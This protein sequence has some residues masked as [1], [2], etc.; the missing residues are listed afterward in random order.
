MRQHL[1]TIVQSAAAIFLIVPIVVVFGWWSPM[2]F[3]GIALLITGVG[4]E[5][6]TV[7]GP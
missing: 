2:W 6:R 7:D 5:R 3:G 4:L 1:A